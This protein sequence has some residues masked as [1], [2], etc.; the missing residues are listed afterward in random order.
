MTGFITPDP[1]RADPRRNTGG[2]PT[3]PRYPIDPT[4]QSRWLPIGI[5]DDDLADVFFTASREYHFTL[6]FN[7]ACPVPTLMRS[8]VP[9][10][11]R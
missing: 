8:P 7:K 10:P 4:Y 5:F 6:H 3:R 2:R 1:A 9:A 11:P